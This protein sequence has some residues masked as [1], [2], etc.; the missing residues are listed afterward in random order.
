MDNN[1]QGDTIITRCNYQAFMY[2][3]MN[4][5]P[6]NIYGI[7]Y[8]L[9]LYMNMN[10]KQQ[11]YEIK[12]YW[13]GT[14]NKHKM[15]FVKNTNSLMKWGEVTHTMAYNIITP[16][17]VCWEGRW[18]WKFKGGMGVQCQVKAKCYIMYGCLE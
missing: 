16:V 14:L 1:L 17:H 13:F 10:L 15:N 18:V 11:I 3:L 9:L 5:Q 7:I 2:G 12:I 4:K 8:L 6:L